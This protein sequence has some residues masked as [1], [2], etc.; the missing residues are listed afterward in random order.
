MENNNLNRRQSFILKW[1]TL[2][3]ALSLFSLILAL[4]R[5]PVF[6]RYLI[7]CGVLGLMYGGTLVVGYSTRAPLLGGLGLAVLLIGEHIARDSFIGDTAYRGSKWN[8]LAQFLSIMCLAMFGMARLFHRKADVEQ[9][10][11]PER[12]RPLFK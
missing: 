8:I 1:S 4:W 11:G 10:V 9:I 12:G 6:F 5:G 7:V 3:V 2:L